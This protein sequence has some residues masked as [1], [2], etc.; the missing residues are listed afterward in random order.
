[1]GTSSLFLGFQLF[2]A[3]FFFYYRGFLGNMFSFLKCEQNVTC[4]GVS[5]LNSPFYPHGPSARVQALWSAGDP[6]VPRDPQASRCQRPVS[7]PELFFLF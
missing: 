5:R 7:D 6:G 2:R 3:L 1:M 4:P